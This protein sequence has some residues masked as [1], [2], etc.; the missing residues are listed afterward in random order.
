M[1]AVNK[2]EVERG[3]NQITRFLAITVIIEHKQM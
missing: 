2:F 3:A 1:Q